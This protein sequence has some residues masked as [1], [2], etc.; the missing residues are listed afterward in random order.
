MQDIFRRYPNRFES[1]ISELCAALEVLEEPDAKAA[2]VWII[3]EFAHRIDNADELL[4]YLLDNFLDEPVPVQLQLLTAAVKLFLKR[5]GLP[6]AQTMISTVLTA[7]TQQSDN[8]DLRDRAFL[9]WRLLSS[10]PEVRTCEPCCAMH[11]VCA[12]HAARAR[13]RTGL[14]SGLHAGIRVMVVVARWHATAPLDGH[15]CPLAG[16]GVWQLTRGSFVLI[17]AFL[18]FWQHLPWSSC[19]LSVC[20]VVRAEASIPAVARLDQ[21]EWLRVEFTMMLY[22]WLLQRSAP[23]PRAC[24]ECSL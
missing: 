4:S 6:E 9:Y 20:N 19:S 8:P 3:G 12:V 1:V 17:R 11:A 24:W 13:L 16:H 21:V 2:M 14:L 18:G 22:R 15:T 23:G 5:P 10:L 7:A